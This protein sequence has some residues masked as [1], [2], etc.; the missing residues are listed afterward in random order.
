MKGTAGRLGAAMIIGMVLVCPARAQFWPGGEVRLPD[1]AAFAN[2]MELGDLDQAK[3]WL[4]AGLS[5][6]FMG[7]RIGSGLMIG[8]WE[9][10][11]PLMRLFLSRG[12]DLYL[13]NGN[14]ETALA[15]AAWRGQLEAVKWLVERGASVNAPPRQWSPLHYAVFGGHA[16][17]AD[18]LLAQGA[19]LEARST[20]GSS[21]L[22]MAVYEGHEALAKQLIERGARRDVRNDWG[23]GALE[24]AM[25]SNHL[26]IARLV[27]DPASY[28]EALNQPKE[29]WG[30]P[31]RSL[32]M[33]RELEAL[34]A[35]RKQVE[36][37]KMSTADLDRLIAA[38]RARIV[39]QQVERPVAP[40]ATALEVTA[41]R[42]K[43]AEQSVRI[44]GQEASPKTFK[45]PPATYSGK[46]KMPPKAP[47]RNY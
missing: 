47:V 16:A 26:G 3:A 46:P 24:W 1:P 35:M 2:R 30:P 13:S 11:I 4:D 34:L 25:R 17:V 12:A 41:R 6:D 21:V 20:N 40:R 38:E 19:D 44:V 9:G 32:F 8:A 18:Y 28:Q 39:R 37:R 42:D 15:L 22:M 27:G 14:G 36:A 5:P 10:N 23:D 29:H 7:S 33:S 45:V 43:P 31:Q